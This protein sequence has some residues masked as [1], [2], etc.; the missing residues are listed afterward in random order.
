MKPANFSEALSLRHVTHDCQRHTRRALQ[1]S[2]VTWRCL[3]A[4]RVTSSLQIGHSFSTEAPLSPGRRHAAEPRHP[5][6]AFRANVIRQTACSWLVGG[7]AGTRSS[8]TVPSVCVR[9]HLEESR[10]WASLL[11]ISLQS[12]CSP[13]LV[14]SFVLLIVLACLC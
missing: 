7:R 14:V 10:H 3:E 12:P 2:A 1:V 4:E 5:A 9:N 6:A 13:F 8:L 11:G